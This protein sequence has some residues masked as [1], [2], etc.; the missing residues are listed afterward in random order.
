LSAHEGGKFVSPI[1]RP[2]LTQGK[3]SRHSFM[4]EIEST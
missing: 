4:L 2:P 1:Q 3:Y